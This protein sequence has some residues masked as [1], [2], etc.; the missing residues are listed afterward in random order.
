M[1]PC[2]RSAM[3]RLRAKILVARKM[4]REQ[5][6][7]RSHGNACYAG[8]RKQSEAQNCTRELQVRSLIKINNY[9]PRPRPDNLHMTKYF[10]SK[11][12]NLQEKIEFQ[13]QITSAALMS[14]ETPFRIYLYR[15]YKF[16]PKNMARGDAK[17][18]FCLYFY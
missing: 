2:E 7:L 17:C 6:R 8:E 13:F 9:S 4:G 10:Y 11:C 18:L 14:G 5:K 12:I 1:L 3:C 16:P 15:R